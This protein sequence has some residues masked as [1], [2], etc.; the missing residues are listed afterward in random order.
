MCTE[1][2]LSRYSPCLSSPQPRLSLSASASSS[3]MP[4]IT[5]SCEILMELY[6]SPT[7][8][9]LVILNELES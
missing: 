5:D 7:S 8:F 3:L 4:T 6:A 1:P 9:R 2:V